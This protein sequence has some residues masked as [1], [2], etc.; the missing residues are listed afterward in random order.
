VKYTLHKNFLDKE[1]FDL[2]QREVIQE[3]FPWYYKPINEIRKGY[4]S[5]SYY[6]NCV[7]NSDL[8]TRHI[9]PILNKLKAVAVIQIRANMFISEFYKGERSKWHTD[10]PFKCTT[11]ILYLNTCDG[12]TE[13]S[14][15]GKTIFIKQ[16]ANTMLIFDS[17]VPHRGTPTKNDDT[18]YLI[19]F[20]YFKPDEFNT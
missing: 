14:V 7:V 8:Y 6:N 10:Y 9:L 16:E 4:F 1:L 13:I 20:N 15:D 19:N 17:D 5:H 2:I 18:R 3:E 11:S 12:G